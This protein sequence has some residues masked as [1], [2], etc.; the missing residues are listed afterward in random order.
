MTWHSHFP[1][2][3]NQTCNLTWKNQLL[4]KPS[5]E[6]WS[7]DYALLLNEK[8]T[9]ERFQLFMSFI[10]NINISVSTAK[11]YS[12]VKFFLTSNCRMK[13]FHWKLFTL[14][15]L[16]FSVSIEN[17]GFNTVFSIKNVLQNSFRASKNDFRASKCW[18]QLAQR[19]SCKITLIFFAPWLS[20]QLNVTEK[21]QRNEH[22]ING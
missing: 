6:K 8:Q 12:R 5:S 14:S 1:L 17:F 4:N 10:N 2:S 19:A 18:L 11:K 22:T 9:D 16:S 15:T 7:S 21:T 13:C 20:L 3:L